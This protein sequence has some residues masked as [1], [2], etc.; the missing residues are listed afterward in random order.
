MDNV[1]YYMRLDLDSCFRDETPDLFPFMRAGATPAVYMANKILLEDPKLPSQRKVGS[2]TLNYLRENNIVPKQM[3]MWVGAFP[4]DSIRLYY[5][6]FEIGSV[7]FFR[8]PDVQAYAD[9]LVNS[10]GIFKY[11]WG[12]AGIRYLTMA[13]YAH[14]HEV[15]HLEDFGVN[16]LHPCVMCANSPF[17]CKKGANPVHWD[18]NILKELEESASTS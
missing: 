3:D 14:E 5:N 6:N 17:K 1:D 11:R 16:Y 4:D 2:L 13:I 12:D 8:R 7:A 10:G 9:M 18:G 15:L